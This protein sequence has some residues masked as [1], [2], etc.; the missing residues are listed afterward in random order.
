VDQLKPWG[1]MVPVRVGTKT[2]PFAKTKTLTESVLIFAK[3]LRVFAK[4]F[5][6]KFSRQFRLFVPNESFA[7]AKTE[8]REKNKSK[9][10]RTNPSTGT[11]IVVW[12]ERG[13][14]A[15]SHIFSLVQSPIGISC[16]DSGSAEVWWS[17]DNSPWG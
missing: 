15:S 8:F 4:G 16:N 11:S 1:R 10:F 13:S 5:R 2:R 3:F 7:K 9:N 12:A 14:L 6:K 17:D